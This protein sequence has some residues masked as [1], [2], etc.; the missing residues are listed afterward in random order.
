MVIQEGREGS[1]NAIKCGDIS[2]FDPERA[3]ISINTESLT[4]GTA[5]DGGRVNKVE[6]GGDVPFP[7][8]NVKQEVVSEEVIL[9]P[10]T[11]PVSTR[12]GKHVFD[13]VVVGE[14][15]WIETLKV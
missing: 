5:V 2:M 10:K 4:T 3:S 13:E 15:H 6:E 12:V 7:S 14:G 1:R 11:K 8:V 9:V